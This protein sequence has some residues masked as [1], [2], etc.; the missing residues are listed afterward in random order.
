MS[1]D[2]DSYEY[3]QGH[4]HDNHH[5]NDNDDENKPNGF[6]C[7]GKISMG[8]RM[9]IPTENKRQHFLLIMMMIMVMMITTMLMTVT[10]MRISLM[11]FHL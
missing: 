5:D 6:I 10:M 3:Q 11:N 9:N 1:V 7:D 2:A 4:H 8:N